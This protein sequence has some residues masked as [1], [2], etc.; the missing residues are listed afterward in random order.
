MTDASELAV[1]WILDQPDP[2]GLFHQISYESRKLTDQ[3]RTCPPHL[4]GLLAVV[5][6]QCLKSFRPYCFLDRSFELRTD[7][8]SFQWFL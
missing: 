6:Y 8:A 1:S 3:E 2:S 4:L 5:H 7:Y